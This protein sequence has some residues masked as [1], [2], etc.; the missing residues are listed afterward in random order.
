MRSFFSSASLLLAGLTSVLAQTACNGRAEYCD[1]PYSNVSQIASH[2][3]AFVGDLP[4][5]NQLWQVSEQL[6]H[7]VRFLSVQTHQSPILKG[8]DMCHTSCIELDAG[9]FKSYMHTI[10][11]FLD[12]NKNEVVTILIVN[13]DFLAPS[14]YEAAIKAA[15]ADKYAYAPKKTL[16]IGEWPTL[17]EMIKQDKRL[18]V[19]MDYKSD[20]AKVPYILDEFTYFF[21]TPYDTTDPKFCQCTLDRPANS[22]PDG[23]MYI[24]NHYLDK[25]LLGISS[26]LVPD[27]DADVQ[28][29]SPTGT[30]SIGAQNDLCV[31]QYKHMPKAVLL[32]YVNTNKWQPAELT[33]NGIH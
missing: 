2:D 6:K 15:G 23:K 3:S 17:G 19:F 10:K 8:L 25:K 16:A 29:N 27:K 20:M 28:T 21:E 24:V 33:M 11:T 7:G 26:I 14:A 4:Q 18:V 30:G 22:K 31:S 12:A 5:D 9:S 13:G 1:R 32:D